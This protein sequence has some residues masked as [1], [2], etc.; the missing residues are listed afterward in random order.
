[1]IFGPAVKGMNSVDTSSID[2]TVDWT[3]DFMT[4]DMWSERIKLESNTTPRFFKI[5]AHVTGLPRISIGKCGRSCLRL[6]M[7]SI[8]INSVLSGFIFNLFV[9]TKF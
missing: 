8:K 3:V 1:M 9:N 2:C 7:E 5:C 6:F 4:C